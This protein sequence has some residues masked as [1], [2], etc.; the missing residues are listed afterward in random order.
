MAEREECVCARGVGGGG[1]NRAVKEAFNNG[2]EMSF[3]NE[4]SSDP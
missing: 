1:L 2:H 4:A 3:I